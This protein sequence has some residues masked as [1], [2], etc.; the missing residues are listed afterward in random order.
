[1]KPRPAASLILAALPLLLA[2]GCKTDS[3]DRS[4]MAPVE[5]PETYST[6][7][8]RGAVP[9]TGWLADFDDPKL[10]ELVAEAQRNNPNLRAAA[11]RMEAVAANARAAGAGLLP[12]A[13]ANSS[14]SRNKRSGAAGFRLTNPVNDSFNLNAGIAWELDLWGKIRNRAKAAS[15]D[16]EASLADYQAARLSLAANTVAGW[17]NTLE[18]QLQVRLS[19]QTLKSFQTNL[20]VIEQGF[21]RGVN[22]ALD[23]RLSRAN[24][25]NARAN[26]RQREQQRDAAVR[27]LE[28][29]LGRYPAN[30]IAAADNLPALTKDIPVGLPSELLRR[31]PDILAAERRLAAS[32]ERFQ[33]ARKDMLPTISLSANGGTQSSELKDILDPDSNVWGFAANLAQP[34]FQGGRL[35]ALAKAGQANVEAS[36]ANYKQTALTAFREVETSLAAAS[37]LREREAALRTATEESSAAEKLAWSA[38]QRGIVDIVTV[39]ESERR[40]FNARSSLIQISNLRLQNRLNLHLALGGDFEPAPVVVAHDRADTEARSASAP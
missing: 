32:D 33:A 24:V 38:Y 36:I 27:A 29:L 13:N 9:D 6:T 8:P 17:F 10:A 40:S 26:L 18:A 37:Y 22:G 2:G 19:E 25:A 21:D 7:A 34:V 28:T 1:M 14:A 35:R 30:R 39:L 11:A 16:H 23:V 5:T 31:R 4:H 3:A 12:S 20:T 15:A